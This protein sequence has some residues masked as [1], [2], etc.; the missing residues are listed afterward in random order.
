M[1][2]ACSEHTPFSH[3][4]NYGAGHHF[5]VP[6]AESRVVLEFLPKNLQAQ[7]LQFVYD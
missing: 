7:S 4:L 5:E 3:H 6:S 1:I 2:S